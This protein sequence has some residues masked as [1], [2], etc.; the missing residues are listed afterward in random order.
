[1]VPGG[2]GGRS[3]SLMTVTVV[4]PRGWGDRTRC[5][6]D[7]SIPAP[8]AIR[9]NCSRQRGHRETGHRPRAQDAAMERG[10]PGTIFPSL[11]LLIATSCSA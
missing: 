4:Q 6:S 1:M 5:V 3:R 2:G 10:S 11:L 7:C 8:S 9:R